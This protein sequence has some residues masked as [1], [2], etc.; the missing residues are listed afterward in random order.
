MSSDTQTS[1]AL[2]LKR[3]VV[4]AVFFALARSFLPPNSFNATV[5][6]F[7]YEFGFTRR[8]LIGELGNFY[9]G[10]TV[11][12]A[13]IFVASAVI[14]LIGLM[15]F[16]TLF[17]RRLAGS[18]AGL[19][20][21]LVIVTCFAF[22]AVIAATGYLDLLIIALLSLGAATSPKSTLGVAARCAAVGIAI[23]IHEVALPY[24]AVFLVFDLWNARRDLLSA[25]P[26][27]LG[28]A[29]FASLTL[30]GQF[31]PEEAVEYI[32]YIEEKSEFTAEPE[33][34]IVVERNLSQ[35]LNM[36][37]EKRRSIGYQ[38]WVVF[39]GI[40]LLLLAAWVLWLNVKVAGPSLTPLSSV[41]LLGAIL[42]PLS[43]NIIAF[44]VVRF[45]AMSVIIG[46]FSLLVFLRDVPE[47]QARLAN[48]LTWP[49]VIVVVVISLN[50]TVTQMNIGT[51]DEFQFP[52]VLLKQ[53]EWLQ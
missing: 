26:L 29:V 51:G 18:E 3:L 4:L 35:N 25:L 40:P 19:R 2:W 12:K 15:T 39:D 50:V 24:I 23:L 43:L 52:R 34:T 32:A 42:A 7:D 11:S 47:A 13:E 31:S 21:L 30:W 27:G 9:W 28:L 49:T 6:I 17:W 38:S 41:L 5:M 8:G 22:D 53:L 45:G 36:M 10:A 20:L 33:A 48:T 44:D 37:A 14:T 1:S 46:F 16:L